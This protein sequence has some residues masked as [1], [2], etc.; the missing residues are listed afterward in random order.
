[1]HS[2]THCC[3]FIRYP[4]VSHFAKSLILTASHLIIRMLVMMARRLSAGPKKVAVFLNEITKLCLK[5]F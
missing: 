2:V 5:V 3:Q 4:S 1:M